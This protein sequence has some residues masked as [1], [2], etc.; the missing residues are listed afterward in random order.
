MTR[1]N[2]A[3]FAIST[4]FELEPVIQEYLEK[5]PNG[6]FKNYEIAFRTEDEHESGTFSYLFVY[7]VLPGQ[8]QDA[9]SFYDFLKAYCTY[10]DRVATINGVASAFPKLG[11]KGQTFGN[12]KKDK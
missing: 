2:Y 4:N 5:Y 11:E 3:Y 6:Q 12:A 10:E 7:T 9:V 8:P 1:P